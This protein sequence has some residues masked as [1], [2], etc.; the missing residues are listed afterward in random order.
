ML[1]EL[2]QRVRGATAETRH[3]SARRGA[4]RQDDAQSSRSGSRP[5][6]PTPDLV[7]RAFGGE[8]NDAATSRQTSVIDI[9]S[10]VLDGAASVDE[11]TLN[12][13]GG[14]LQYVKSLDESTLNVHG[15]MV[16]E[17]AS[18]GNHARLNI[19]GGSVAGDMYISQQGTMLMS[20]GN[21]GGDLFLQG[22]AR[23]F[24]EAARFAYDDDQD[25]ST[26]LVEID[27]GPTGSLDLVSFS[28]IFMDG[29]VGSASGRV[30]E[31]LTITWLNG[32]T[33]SFDLRAY[34]YGV[35]TD[36]SGTLTLRVPTPEASVITLVGG[37][38][39]LRRRR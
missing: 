15:G 35:S 36:W 38:G 37:I 22:N 7:R 34:F 29:P 14:S 4:H 24:L 9:Y 39:L 21:L 19:Y 12:V 25:D 30:I 1:A 11:S 3:D 33:T 8:I 26:D 23:V 2:E 17:Y 10:G 28:P 18:A 6:T 27:L 16:D 5:T 32:T 20:G 13:W 31:D